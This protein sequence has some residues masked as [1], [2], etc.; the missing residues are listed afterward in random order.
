LARVKH[1]IS[2]LLVN[3][4]ADQS[5]VEYWDNFF[6][7]LPTSHEDARYL[8]AVGDTCPL[9][10]L[11][12]LG[13]PFCDIVLI[14][15]LLSYCF[16]M[17]EGYE[18]I[19]PKSVNRFK[20]SIEIGSIIESVHFKDAAREA[21]RRKVLQDQASSSEHVRLFGEMES[22]TVPAL[23]KVDKRTKA[24]KDLVVSIFIEFIQV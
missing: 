12:L 9:G 17:T 20:P 18:E 4:S 3:K 7:A 22:L 23:V 14:V 11:I 10:Q 19:R 1:N 21:H 24:Y 8:S 13:K 5:A 16:Q 15:V 6:E 2:R